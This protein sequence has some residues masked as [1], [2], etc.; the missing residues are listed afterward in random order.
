MEQIAFQTALGS[1]ALAWQKNTVVA[2]AFGHRSERGALRSL[3]AKIKCL[4]P[5][6]V[7]S[8][9]EGCELE[10][11]VERLRDFAEGLPTDFSDVH[12]DTGRY[13][14]FQQRVL[15]ACR[16]IPWG[17]TRTYGQLARNINRPGAAR[18]VGTVMAS[19]CVPLVVPCHR[20]VAASGGLGGFSAP[21]GLTMKRR[22][23]ANEQLAT[24]GLAKQT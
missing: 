7:S 1:L 15:N 18:A 5:I 9:S 10:E 20:V 2:L 22:L 19:N 14:S 17:E 23:L 11:L 21:Q 4:P 6:D 24:C 12:L 8:K 16:A 13:T 3:E